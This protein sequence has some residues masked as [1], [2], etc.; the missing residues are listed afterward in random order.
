MG[1]VVR[2]CSVN[3]FVALGVQL[4]PLLPLAVSQPF[5][6]VEVFLFFVNLVFMEGKTM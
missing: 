3:V 6:L 2:V 5:D 4:G 1:G